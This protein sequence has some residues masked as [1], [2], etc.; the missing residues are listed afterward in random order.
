[1][2]GQRRANQILSPGKMWNPCLGLSG[3]APV[4]GMREVPTLW[5]QEA[6][7]GL[8]SG[9]SQGRLIHLD[10]PV[11][12]FQKPSPLLPFLSFHSQILAAE[13]TVLKR[14]E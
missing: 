3:L 6:R 9:A 11:F 1:M 4:P 8:A 10:F 7:N 5:R 13:R 2:L 12:S 14:G